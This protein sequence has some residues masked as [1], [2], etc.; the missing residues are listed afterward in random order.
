MS[1]A[2]AKS[3]EPG[4]VLAGAASA[5]GIAVSTMHTAKMTESS[6]F[7]KFALVIREYLRKQLYI[8]YF[9]PFRHECKA[10]KFNYAKYFAL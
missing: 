6:F 4:F 8:M 9:N 2:V 1:E 7:A 10:V 5:A 3:S